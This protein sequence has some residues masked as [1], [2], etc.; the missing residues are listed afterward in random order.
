[1]ESR[2]SRVE[3]IIPVAGCEQRNVKAAVA[4]QPYFIELSVSPDGGE[5]AFIS[6]VDIWTVRRRAGSASAGVASSRRVATA[7]LA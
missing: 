3:A 1:M 7:V 6:G 2:R 4:P 5:I